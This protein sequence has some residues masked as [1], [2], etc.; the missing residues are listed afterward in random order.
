LPP[1]SSGWRLPNSP[2]YVVLASLAA[3]VT[4]GLL[5]LARLIGLAFLADFLSR[6]VLIGFLTGVGI[7]VAAGQLA[8]MLGLPGGGTGTIDKGAD[9]D[10]A[11]RPDKCPDAHRRGRGAGRNRCSADGG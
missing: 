5:L 8:G 10:V 6:A 1:D 7:Q 4:A 3:L 2:T 9:R 11:N